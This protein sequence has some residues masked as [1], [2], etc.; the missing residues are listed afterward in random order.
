MTRVQ[1]LKQA[2][3]SWG[4]A[5]GALLGLVGLSSNPVLVSLAVRFGG[6]APALA[7]SLPTSVFNV[8]TAVGTASA[9]RRVVGLNS[10]ICMV[11]SHPWR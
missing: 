6:D 1:N 10:T 11:L 9:N 8:G 7:A 3:R 2:M 4:I 5:V